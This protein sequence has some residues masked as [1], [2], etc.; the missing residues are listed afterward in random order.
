M[1]LGDLKT[2]ILG[3]LGIP[4]CQQILTGWKKD[5]KSDHTSL[6]SLGLPRENLLFLTTPS[7]ADN[8]GMSID[9]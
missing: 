6:N 1:I 4:Y 7:D 8:N 5:P 2:M 3:N 9:G